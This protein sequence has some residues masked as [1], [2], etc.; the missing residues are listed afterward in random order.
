VGEG[1]VNGKKPGHEHFP[2]TKSRT[3]TDKWGENP[4][5][6]R[7]P[8]VQESKVLGKIKVLCFGGTRGRKDE[9]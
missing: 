5:G 1:K 4:R 8:V 2:S 9:K 3:G 6:T 7:S